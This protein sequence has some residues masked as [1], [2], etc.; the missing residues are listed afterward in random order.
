MNLVIIGGKSAQK[1]SEIV[2]TSFDDITVLSYQDINIF[3]QEA[4]L[5]GLEIHR[6]VLLQDGI[7]DVDDDNVYSFVDF[8][9]TYYP[10]IRIITISKDTDTVKFLGDLLTS[11]YCVHFYF[12]SQKITN[13]M[14]LDIVASD[15]STLKTKYKN[16][17]YKK[18]AQG[19]TNV[20][21]A[22]D[23][24]NIVDKGEETEIEP[25][26]KRGFFSKVFG[27]GPKNNK[28]SKK[29]VSK[30]QG[31]K[32][33][34]QGQGV[35][36]FTKVEP[37]IFDLENQGQQD[38][39]SYEYTVFDE[40]E[41]DI[42]VGFVPESQTGKK[43]TIFDTPMDEEV[44]S[45]LEE[46]NEDINEDFEEEYTEEEV[47]EEEPNENYEDEEIEP[48]TE[49]EPNDLEGLSNLDLDIN[50]DTDEEDLSFSVE[51]EDIITP[52]KTNIESIKR[53]MQETEIEDIS[54]IT[55]RNPKINVDIDLEEV[56]SDLPLELDTDIS[57]IMQ[58]Y[59]EQRSTANVKVVEKVIK[60]PVKESKNIRNK[61]GVRI[62][63]V[64]GDRRTGVT[65]LSMNLANYFAKEERTL[66]VD[67][68]RYRKGIVSYMGVEEII[69]EP[70]HI[71]NGLNHVKNEKM[72]PNVTYLYPK[73]GF[74]S[75]LSLY[76]EEIED[77]Q[78]IIAQKVISMQKHY[79]TV[80]IDCPLENLY[81]MNNLLY[82]SNILIC[83]EDDRVGIINAV[84][85][86]NSSVEDEFMPHL[87]N[88]SAFV[89]GR[90]SNIE[91]FKT[92]MAYV[93]S[94]F[95]MDETPYNW[96]SLEIKGTIKGTK[97]L[98]EGLVI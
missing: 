96:G 39:T 36:E 15:V 7:D 30:A 91:K 16:L 70:A 4:S 1:L 43:G 47:V 59:E 68:D 20:V 2:K 37:T 92:E 10:S 58:N 88:N 75:L 56:D 18:E 72:L 8:I 25:E 23:V 46:E 60:V 32:P 19:Y 65:K 51:K 34:G 21:D 22:P 53:S 90:G 54:D 77:E 62:L 52:V 50:E 27:T 57:T 13:K 49:E 44:E 71:Q 67:F 89:I 35:E 80:V 81:L 45:T 66:L 26:V 11:S 38:E 83:I 5:R 74:Y 84:I 40:Q 41:G 17:I 31:L 87:Y 78:M 6:L 86:L 94:I 61:N 79:T 24:R 64:T 28:K 93:E 85:N 29:S 14:V 76:G 3:I 69:N 95:G 9:G 97:K 55:V 63:L 82:N 73:G 98:A 33:I 42:G 12:S 48:I